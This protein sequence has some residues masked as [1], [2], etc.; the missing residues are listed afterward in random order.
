MQTEEIKKI[1]TDLFI[2]SINKSGIGQ[3]HFKDNITVDVEEQMEHLNV[4]K[5]I[6]DNKPTPFVVTAGEGVTITKE[7]RDNALVIEPLSPICA[8]AVV[9]QNLAYRIIAEFYIKVQ[10]PKQPYK[11]F[12]DKEKAFEWCKQF[13]KQTA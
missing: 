7:A 10:K 11:V 4:L 12:T 13:V 6:T 5:K 1:E 2:T 9:V 3:M 8:T